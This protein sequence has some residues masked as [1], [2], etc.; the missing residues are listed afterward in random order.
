L[1]KPIHRIHSAQK[2]KLGPVPILAILPGSRLKEIEF[3]LPK[4]IQIVNDFKDYQWIVSA[5]SNIPTTVYDSIIKDLP[6][7]LC[8]VTPMKS[9]VRQKRPL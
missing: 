3:L 8:T 7:E 5:M 2:F 6:V 1:K 4:A 9:S